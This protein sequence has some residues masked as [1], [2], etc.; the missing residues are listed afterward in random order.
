[1]DSKT[2]FATMSEAERDYIEW[3]HNNRDYDPKPDQ[4]LDNVFDYISKLYMINF[5]TKF[6]KFLCQ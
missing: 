2:I 6:T 4:I 1:M 5:V 3:Y